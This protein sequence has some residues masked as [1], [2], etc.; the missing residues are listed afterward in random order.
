MN[1]NIKLLCCFNVTLSNQFPLSR[2]SQIKLSV[3]FFMQP[4]LQQI[5]Y[6][7]SLQKLNLRWQ[8]W[9]YFTWF[10]LSKRWCHCSSFCTQWRQKQVGTS[11]E[12]FIP[13]KTGFETENFY[14]LFTDY[15]GRTLAY[16]KRLIFSQPLFLKWLVVI[17]TY[18]KCWQLLA[19]VLCVLDEI[20]TQTSYVLSFQSQ[21]GI[22]GIIQNNMLLRSIRS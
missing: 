14:F 13:L 9:N 5:I 7:P 10:F 19:I 22:V 18:F 6:S 20:V 4:Y 3:E 12:H 15:R 16:P 21:R 8:L 17:K 1:S 2:I 11:Q